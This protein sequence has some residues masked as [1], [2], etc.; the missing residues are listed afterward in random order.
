ME[1]NRIVLDGRRSLARQPAG[2]VRV[3]P[4]L[5]ALPAGHLRRRRCP[6]LRQFEGTHEAACH[7]PV[8]RWPMTEE[9]LQ[10]TLARLRGLTVPNS[11]RSVG[12]STG[13]MT[14]WR[15]TTACERAAQW[16]SLELDGELGRLEQ[17]ALARHLRRCDRCLASSEEIG[18]LH[19]S[20]SAT[21]R[22][23]SPREP[24]SWSRPPGPSGG[25]VR[26]SVAGRWHSPRHSPRWPPLP[27]CR[28]RAASPPST[29]GFSD[30][31]QQQA[32]ARDHV[33]GEPTVFARRGAAV[34]SVVRSARAPIDSVLGGRP[35][36]VP[37]H[38]RPPSFEVGDTWPRATAAAR[39]SA[40]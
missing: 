24:W 9:E 14:R 21:R 31:Q 2:G 1:R 22:R 8:E 39:T 18:A 12:V 15:R 4:A 30:A 36:G 32:F 16:I 40:D 28:I 17:A 20:C 10:A 34:G 19:R 25:H 27:C 29:I 11:L 26:R 3:P 6:E 23:S 5:P 13:A 35:S 7:F 33:Q 37:R 38:R